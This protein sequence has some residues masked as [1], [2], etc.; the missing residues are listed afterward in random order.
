MAGALPSL[1]T[2]TLNSR[3]GAFQSDRTSQNVDI[4]LLCVNYRWGG[5]IIAEY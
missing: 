2:L 5:P 4:G 3:G 1:A